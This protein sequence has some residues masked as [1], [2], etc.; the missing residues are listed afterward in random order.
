V[1]TRVCSLSRHEHAAV[2]SLRRTLGQITPPATR[3]ASATGHLVRQIG[4]CYL[5]ADYQQ[6]RPFPG[7][8]RLPYN[9]TLYKRRHKIENMFAN[10]PQAFPT[11][12]VCRNLKPAPLKDEGRNAIC[13][14]RCAHTFFSAVVSQLQSLSISINEG[15]AWKPKHNAAADQRPHC[16]WMISTSPP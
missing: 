13:Y 3:A 4:I 10:S 2:S 8:S 16:N 14:D 7:C 11:G 15:G 12:C 5:V 6:R 9:K 1:H